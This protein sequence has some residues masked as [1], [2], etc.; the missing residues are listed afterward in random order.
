[1]M[2]NVQSSRA[3]P[4]YETFSN[5]IASDAELSLYRNFHTL[6]SRNLLYLQS[7]LLELEEKLKRLDGE[8]LDQPTDDVKLSSKCWEVLSE[9]SKKPDS[10]EEKRMKIIMDI[11]GTIK[12]YQEALL[13]QSQVLNL[14]KPSI[15]VF[16]VFKNWFE[17][18]RPFVGYGSNIPQQ[19]E[20][21]V[22][23]HPSPDQDFLTRIFQDVWGRYLPGSRHGVYGEV[24][25]YSSTNV[26]RLATVITVL[27]AS[28]VIDGAIVAL[29]LVANQK[30]RLGL[31]ALFI[32][33]FA[34]SL[35]VL[36]DAKRTDMIL[37][38]A[39]CAAVLVVFI[40]KA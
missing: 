37:A 27:A 20:E 16:R 8:D 33:I 40:S 14:P 1:M 3:F 31:S 28:L 13:L 32:S 22:A 38:T 5:F 39:A 4:S 6:S 7:C 15:R 24:K 12:E 21:F 30:I 11:K 10:R 2:T 19:R 18:E 23:L 17:S 35:A 25:Y 9:K 29:Y 34:A 26:S 36:T